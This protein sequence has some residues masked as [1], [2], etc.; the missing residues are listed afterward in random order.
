M[1]ENIS[2]C[3]NRTYLMRFSEEDGYIGKMPP[4]GINSTEINS[5]ALGKLRMIGSKTL[6]QDLEK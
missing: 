6:S 3:G 5:H 2:K 1:S 4:K